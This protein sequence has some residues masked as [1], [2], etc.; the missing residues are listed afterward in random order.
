LAQARA[1]FA[2]L[3]ED[4]RSWCQASLDRLRAVTR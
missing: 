2:E 1:A 4:D 3:D